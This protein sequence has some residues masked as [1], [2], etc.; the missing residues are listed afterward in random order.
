VRSN[1]NVIS[2]IGKEIGVTNIVNWAH[3]KAQTR[4]NIRVASTENNIHANAALKQEG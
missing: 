4:E 2:A 1:Q 3:K